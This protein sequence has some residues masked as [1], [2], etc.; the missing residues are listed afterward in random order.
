MT[1][2]NTSGAINTVTFYV[3]D[4]PIK[5]PDVNLTSSV[6]VTTQL[7][8]ILGNCAAAGLADFAAVT[9]LANTAKLFA[10]GSTP[11]RKCTLLAFKAFGTPGNAP[12]ANV[13]QVMIGVSANH[14]PIVLNPGDVWTFEAP[15]GAKYD[16]N[17]F[18]VSSPN[19]GDGVLVI[20]S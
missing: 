8:N 7:T 6:S 16:F 1:F 15:T 10:A 2:Y 18:Y 14:Q 3:S 11:F 5:L 13:G 9:A 19:A 17:G 20:W 4:T 12:T